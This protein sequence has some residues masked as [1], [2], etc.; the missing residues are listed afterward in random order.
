[1]VCSAFAQQDGNKTIQ[2]M[3]AKADN[4]NE[5][6]VVVIGSDTE[7][8]RE[9]NVGQWCA[10]LDQMQVGD[11]VEVFGVWDS[12][13]NQAEVIV[14][15]RTKEAYVWVEPRSNSIRE[16]TY[17]TGWP[18]RTRYSSP[19]HFAFHKKTDAH[20]SPNWR[21]LCEG[22]VTNIVDE[23]TIDLVSPATR[24]Q[25]P[26]MDE[27]HKPWL[28][29]DFHR[30][31]IQGRIPIEPKRYRR[32]G[33]PGPV[34]NRKIYQD[35]AS[36]GEL[37]SE[38]SYVNLFGVSQSGGCANLRGMSISG[39]CKAWAFQGIPLSEVRMIGRGGVEHQS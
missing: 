19:E 4:P 29:N 8:Q 38:G 35:H 3:G 12:S 37:V 20:T 24:S 27:F 32:M 9:F 28:H 5:V 31:V 1:M 23:H 7:K 25:R 17:P 26:E 10:S 15:Y 34:C 33:D 18:S 21:T 14:N 6:G 11:P 39:Y 13:R 2:G 30:F 36:I 22:V 16:Y